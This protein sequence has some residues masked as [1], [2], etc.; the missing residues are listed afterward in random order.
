MNFCIR[1][2][3]F[4][5]QLHYLLYMLP[6]ILFYHAAP[7][8]F[9]STLTLLLTP[10]LCHLRGPVLQLLLQRSCLLEAHEAQFVSADLHLVLRLVLITLRHWILF[11]TSR[12]AL[13]TIGL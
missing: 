8:F 7:T 11:I 9:L 12:A 4:R 6:L 5:Q 1:N 3:L 13:F 10:Q 2:D